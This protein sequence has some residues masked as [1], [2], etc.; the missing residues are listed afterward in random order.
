MDD[1]PAQVLLFNR[2]ADSSRAAR[3][4]AATCPLVAA[5]RK[6]HSK[7]AVIENDLEETI[8]DLEERQWPVRYCKCT[9]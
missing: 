3:V 7:V 2:C 5:A 9:K 1:Q 8:A 6:S 4:H